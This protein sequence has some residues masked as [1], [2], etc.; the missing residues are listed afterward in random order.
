MP[1]EYCI[2][3]E[4]PYCPCCPFHHMDTSNCETYEDLDDVDWECL[5]TKEKY[6]KYMAEKEAP[7]E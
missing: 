2:M 4:M 5:C 7:N 3:P 6:E 1:T